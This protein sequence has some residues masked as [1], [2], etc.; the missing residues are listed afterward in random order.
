MMTEIEI[1]QKL[2]N[3]LD[4]SSQ[5]NSKTIE[6]ASQDISKDLDDDIPF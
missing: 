3:I 1:A 5:D 2:S 6:D 4:I